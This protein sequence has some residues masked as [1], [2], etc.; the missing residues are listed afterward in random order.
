M[1]DLIPHLVSYMKWTLFW[2]IPTY[3]NEMSDLGRQ[4]SLRRQNGIHTLPSK[5]SLAPDNCPLQ[6]QLC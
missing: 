3:H 4:W 6:R 5:P 1:N 2:K